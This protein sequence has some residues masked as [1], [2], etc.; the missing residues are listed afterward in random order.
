[1]G[2][3]SIH[4]TPEIVFQENVTDAIHYKEE[5]LKQKSKH[6][7]IDW[8][9][10]NAVE[11]ILYISITRKNLQGLICIYNLCILT[12]YKIFTFYFICGTFCD[13]SC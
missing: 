2:G 10:Q 7:L 4:I 11:R 12:Q 6:L 13:G 8:P 9:H 3:G 1:M 5:T